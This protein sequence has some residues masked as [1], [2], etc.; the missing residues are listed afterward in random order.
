[1]K[2]RTIV[3]AL[4]AA[5]AVSAIAFLGSGDGLGNSIGSIGQKAVDGAIGMFVYKNHSGD[6]SHAAQPVDHAARVNAARARSAQSADAMNGGAQGDGAYGSDVIDTATEAAQLAGEGS[7]GIA[8]RA[9]QPVDGMAVEG[10]PNASTSGSA[11]AAATDPNAIN[12][13]GAVDVALGEPV[14]LETEGGESVSAPSSTNEMLPG[15][16]PPADG[17]ASGVS[18]GSVAPS[19]E[20]GWSNSDPFE[21]EDESVLR[22]MGPGYSRFDGRDPFLALITANNQ[23]AASATVDPDGMRFV[24]IIWGDRGI[25]ALVEDSLRRGYVLREGDRVLYGRV[26][27]ISRDRI[28]VDQVIHGEFKRV[29]LRLE[30][31]SREGN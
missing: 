18:G 13:A 6:S 1:M 11:G 4:V 25:R 27:S 8:D 26:T 3:I 12:P 7:M 24:G 29:T 15:G 10:D 20:D 5:L 23:G 30:P 9:G 28:V 21:F 17:A 31:Y 22:E 2:S 14:V 19:S 16:Q